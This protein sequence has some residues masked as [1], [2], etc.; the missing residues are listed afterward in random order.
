M[1]AAREMSLE[2]ISVRKYRAEHDEVF[3]EEAHPFILQ[4]VIL[5]TRI[6]YHID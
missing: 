4:K 1:I 3:V 5:S 2:N 6:Y